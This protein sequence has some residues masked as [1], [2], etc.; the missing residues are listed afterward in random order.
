M[1]VTIQIPSALRQHSGGRPEVLVE[2]TTIGDA[3]AQL[4]KDHEGIRQHLF[5]ENGEVR[6]FINV[7]LGDEDVRFLDGPNTALTDGAV[8]LLVPAIAGGS[9]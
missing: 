4:G 1:P 9:Q 6:R 3:L 8:I 2:A 5:N 7:F